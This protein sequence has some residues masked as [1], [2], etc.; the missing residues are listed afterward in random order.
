MRFNYFCSKGTSLPLAGDKP[1]FLKVWS[2]NSRKS[3]AEVSK[4]KRI[5]FQVYLL[6]RHCPLT[7]NHKYGI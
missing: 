3:G 5:K 6:L 1:L 4:L 7:I 2:D